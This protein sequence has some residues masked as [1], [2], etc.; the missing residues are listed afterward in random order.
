MIMEK[1]GFLSVWIIFYDSLKVRILI[2]ISF[3]SF[4]VG[5]FIISFS[6]VSI[7]LFSLDVIKIF[8]LLVQLIPCS[9]FHILS[10]LILIHDS[11]FLVYKF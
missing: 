11:S 6:L 2:N 5:K 7:H 9:Y 10:L 4:L 1:L 3:A 8:S